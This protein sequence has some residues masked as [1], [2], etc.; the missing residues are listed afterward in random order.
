MASKK[1]H[2]KSNLINKRS[3]ITQLKRLDYGHIQFTRLLAPI[4]FVMAGLTLLKVYELSFTI[5]Q[6][7]M[8]AGGA[9]ASMY[10][11]GLIWDNTGLVEEEI[12]YINERN[13]FVRVMLKKNWIRKLSKATIKV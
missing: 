11:I 2:K 10:I 1:R 6:I 5:E 8:L 4:S 3:L 9:L 7:I 12:E 13:R